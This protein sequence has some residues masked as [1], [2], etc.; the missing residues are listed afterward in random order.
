MKIEE[1][2]GPNG[3]GIL[4]IA[5]VRMFYLWFFELILSLSVFDFYQIRRVSCLDFVHELITRLSSWLM[6]KFFIVDSFFHI[7]YVKT[8]NI[9]YVIYI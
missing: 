1:G 2:F 7:R 9:Q 3:L 5:D 8:E 6:F 4:T